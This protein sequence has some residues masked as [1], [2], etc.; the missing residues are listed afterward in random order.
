MRAKNSIFDD[1][2]PINSRI[3]K[4]HPTKGTHC[5]LCFEKTSFDSYGCPQKPKTFNEIKTRHIKYIYSG[6]KVH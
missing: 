2:F 6:K 4:L 3:L 1:F 5:V